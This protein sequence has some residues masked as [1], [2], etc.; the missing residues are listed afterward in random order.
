MLQSSCIRLLFC[1]CVYLPTSFPRTI[2]LP[3][4]DFVGYFVMTHH[5]TCQSKTP[6]HSGGDPWKGSVQFLVGH[7]IAS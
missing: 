3:E 1:R 7:V 6:S 5:M 4:Q 2:G